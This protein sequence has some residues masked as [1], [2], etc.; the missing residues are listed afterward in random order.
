MRGGGVLSG[1]ISESSSR[2]TSFCRA[3]LG[4]FWGVVKVESAADWDSTLSESSEI[5]Y[6]TLSFRRV[7]RFSD[8]AIGKLE[9]D[10]HG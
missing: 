1:S 5:W 8:I 4:I 3:D 2:S 10:A 7:A 9:G 6:D